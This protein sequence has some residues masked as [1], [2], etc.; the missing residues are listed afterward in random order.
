M[1]GLATELAGRVEQALP[2]GVDTEKYAG[3]LKRWL[4]AQERWYE[5][6]QARTRSSRQTVPDPYLRQRWDQFLRR[7]PLE[8]AQAFATWIVMDSSIGQT[9]ALDSPRDVEVF[10]AAFGAANPDVRTNLLLGTR[11]RRKRL[12]KETNRAWM[13]AIRDLA[14]VCDARSA[15]FLFDSYPRHS[16][17]LPRDE[18]EEHLRQ[19]FRLLP[20]LSSEVRQQVLY[21]L[22]SLASPEYETGPALTV[23]PEFWE[24]LPVQTRQQFLGS[25]LR[26]VKKAAAGAATFGKDG[27]KVIPFLREHLDELTQS[28]LTMLWKLPDAFSPEEWIRLEGSTKY[29]WP[30][31]PV[32]ELDRI[33]RAIAAD[34]SD[35]NYAE[36]RFIHGKASPEVAKEIFTRGV[37]S[38]DP[39]VRRL[40]VQV[41]NERGPLPPKALEKLLLDLTSEEKPDLEL[42]RHLTGIVLKVRPS[43]S[44]FP[45]TRLLLESK[46]S[47]DRLTG[48]RIAHS[49]GRPDLVPDLAELLDSMDVTIRTDAKRAIDS[50]RE[51]QRIKNEEAMKKA[52]LIPK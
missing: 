48:I 1:A 24:S 13:A 50:I 34:L 39:A 16:D 43:E 26:L 31:T 25:L 2:D 15:R 44:L 19:V 37:A 21:A 5:L 38:E 12:T 8:D 28:Q 45:A 29:S 32:A 47:E 3:L 4:P 40:F 20:N 51:V 36:V 27:E 10:R 11:E 17:L 35:T 46:K 52:G 22:L 23:F 49:L 42:V 6:L 30:G 41:L 14:P 7:A 18:A 9:F 33:A